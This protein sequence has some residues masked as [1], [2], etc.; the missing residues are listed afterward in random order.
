[1]LPR[2]YHDILDGS[3]TDFSGCQSM[4]FFAYRVKFDFHPS[5]EASLNV[6]TGDIVLGSEKSIKSGVWILVQQSTPPYAHGY[7]PSHYL[8][9]AQKDACFGKV[10]P[11]QQEAN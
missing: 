8:E 2:K 5:D 11:S 1:M 7:V 3:L 9:R 10:S 6:S 4:Q